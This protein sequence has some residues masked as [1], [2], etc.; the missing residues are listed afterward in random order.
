MLETLRN[1]TKTWVATGFIGLLVL[2]F[3]IWGVND[4]FRGGQATTLA[5]VGDAELHIRTFENEYARQVRRQL[6]AQGNPMSAAEGRQAGYDRI[7]LDEMVGD[8]AVLEEAR[9]VGL[10]AS[11]EMVR[12]ALY[13]IQ[14]LLMPD[15]SIDRDGLGRF[16]QNIGYTEEEFL[17]AIRYDLMR[18]QLLQAA[19]L[20]P[21]V[22]RGFG[23]TLQAYV[24]ER[25]TIEYVVL[26]PEK[27]GEIT[28]PDDAALQAYL[29]ANA[30][31]YTV[32]ELRAV[33]VLSYGPKDVLPS[34]DIPEEAVKL[35]YEAQKH[36]YE[37]LETR[38]LQQIVYPT[39]AEADAAFATLSQGKSFDDLA[40]ERQLKAEDI[41]LGTIQ[42]GDSAVPGGAFDVAEG[43]VSAPLEG[44]FGWALV[45]V[46]K[47]NP[48]SLK[49]FEEVRQEVRD[50][51]AMEQAIDQISEM[52]NRIQDE[53]AATDSLE[54]AAKALNLTVR[55]IPGVDA[56]G[57]DIDGNAIEDLPDGPGFLADV[58]ALDQG[59]RSDVI[60]TDGHTLYAVRVDAITNSAVRPLATIRDKVAAEWIAAE[61]AKRLKALA[62]D[63]VAR[64][65][66]TA[67][68]IAEIGKELGL[69]GKTTEA[70]A[71]DAAPG[72]LSPKLLADLFATKKGVWVSGPA[73]EAPRFA[74]ARVKE[75]TSFTSP[76]PLADELALRQAES[77]ALGNDLAEV[78]RQEVVKS[79]PVKID[80]TL[81][82]QTRRTQ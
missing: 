46:L 20:G 17:S 36:R 42:K 82:E 5:E 68:G 10:T 34:I 4:I 63:I 26:P 40:A 73:A 76:D 15:G 2:S 78:Y 43:E 29:D 71:R 58:F 77:G 16:L 81:F 47:I 72:D 69:E 60:E 6:N 11:D 30:A 31:A 54:E 52:I 61:Q 32:P 13:G 25:R 65:N 67:N 62:D 57:R 28:P 22:P 66:G 3:A 18:A 51:L 44:P 1:A 37:T 75:V 53:L 48:G 59:Q 35:G 45:K 70:L 19:T 27:A 9:R 49:P 21:P 24:N 74:V 23:L 12:G 41:A 56:R 39:K 79:T 14:G 55:T 8:L 80:E 38:E 7:V 64:S 50:E 33:T